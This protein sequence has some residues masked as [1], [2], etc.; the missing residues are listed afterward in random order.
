ML[1]YWKDK[2]CTFVTELSLIKLYLFHI[3]L[4]VTCNRNK[5]CFYTKD[6][7]RTEAF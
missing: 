1:I 7:A 3:H 6:Y 4:G 5:I 2:V